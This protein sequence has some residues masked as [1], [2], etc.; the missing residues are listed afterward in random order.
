MMM[1]MMFL[2]MLII[3][4]MIIDF[5][6]VVDNILYIIVVDGDI[7]M[8]MMMMIPFEY[9]LYK[10][11]DNFPTMVMKQMANNSQFY[12]SPSAEKRAVPRPLGAD[13]V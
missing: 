10:S 4:I 2:L 3:K 12:D 11:L 8:M 6:M 5:D 7:L 9:S 13:T 1:M